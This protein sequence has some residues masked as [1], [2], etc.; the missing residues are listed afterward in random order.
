VWK[1]ASTETLGGTERA[2]H[3]FLEWFESDALIRLAA[4]FWFVVLVALYSRGDGF[5]ANWHWDE[6]SKVEQV[7]GAEPNFVHPYLLLALTKA[8]LWVAGAQVVPQEIVIAGRLVSAVAAAGAV[9]A[10]AMAATLLAG[11]LAAALTA[12]L[13]G[14]IPLFFDLAHFMKEDALLSFGLAAFV[15]A[16]LRYDDAPGRWRLAQLGAA[17]GFACAGKY[18]GAVSIPIGLVVVISISGR[19]RLS[20]VRPCLTM[21]AWAAAVFVAA[22]FPALLDPYQFVYGLHSGV[23]RVTDHHGGFV[24][25]LDSDFYLV[26]LMQLC[27]IA[28]LAAY[29]AWLVRVIED[30]RRVTV[31]RAI[32]A[33]LPLAYLA[34]L[35]VSPLKMIRYEL[36]VVALLTMLG[37]SAIAGM[38]VGTTRWPIRALAAAVVVYLFAVNVAGVVA[39]E[40]T[41]TNDTRLDMARWIRANLPA[42]AFIAEESIAGMNAA[43]TAAADATIP[44]KMIDRNYLPELGTRADLLRRGVTHVLI[45]DLAFG[46]F[47]NDTLTVDEH[48][49]VWVTRIKR[50]RAFYRDL[51][52]S[53]TLLHQSNGATPPGTFIAPGLWLFKLEPTPAA[54]TVPPRA[55]PPVF[56]QLED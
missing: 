1:P 8:A 30:R 39:S 13:V 19:L 38:L 36:P 42:N 40:R 33:A 44:M 54:G 23:A 7:L 41:M 25:P 10:L 6:P 43:G 31:A 45:A 3:A 16:V 48:D 50:Y 5:P 24:R 56:H 37:A 32:V 47:F 18:V 28:M 17:A 34:M 26:G 27:P 29:G 20:P 4:L 11:R 14:T 55:E 46:R 21:I 53:A 12:V 2:R 9:V 52:A 22:N 15:L 51:F 35:Q 49:L